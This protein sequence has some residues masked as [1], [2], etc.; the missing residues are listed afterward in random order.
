MVHCQ[1]GEAWNHLCILNTSSR[2]FCSIFL[3]PPNIYFQMNGIHKSKLIEPI[4]SVPITFIFSAFMMKCGKKN[5]TASEIGRIKIQ[6]KI[7]KN[8]ATEFNFYILKL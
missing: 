6:V 2:H 5:R 1:H 8:L 4:C 3:T 7:K